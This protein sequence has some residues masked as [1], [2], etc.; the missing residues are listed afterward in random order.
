MNYTGGSRWKGRESYTVELFVF[1]F[2]KGLLLNICFSEY[3]AVS[4]RLESQEESTAMT[5]FRKSGWCRRGDERLSVPSG[6]LTMDKETIH[7]HL[8]DVNTKHSINQC[9]P[10]LQGSHR[11]KW[12]KG[13]LRPNFLAKHREL[14]WSVRLFFFTS[15]S[16]FKTLFKCHHVFWLSLTPLLHLQG[17]INHSL[18]SHPQH[19]RNVFIAA[20]TS[21]HFS[22]VLISI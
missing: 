22:D 18:D 16:Y 4:L 14:G 11:R 21:V 7:R 8:K 1:R 5:V 6:T 12:K 17:R 20:L 9:I 13:S 2:R 10:I 19:L 15:Y 3:G